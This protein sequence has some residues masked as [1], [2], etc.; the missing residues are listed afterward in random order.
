MKRILVGVAV[1]GALGV[2]I[3]YYINSTKKLP[4]VA[5]V[6]SEP[7][8]PRRGPVIAKPENAVPT[9]DGAKVAS[10]PAPAVSLDLPP[11]FKDGVRMYAN[12]HWEG[13]SRLQVQFLG[14]H[15]GV[16]PGKGYVKLMPL[17]VP[18]KARPFINTE[19]KWISTNPPVYELWHRTGARLPNDFRAVYVRGGTW[20][21][22]DLERS[23]ADGDQVVVTRPGEHGKPY[24][25]A[26]A[27]LPSKSKK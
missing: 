5:V 11:K 2:G 21:F 9:K 8:P 19:G 23:Y 24:V 6:P 18:D 27:D 10:V 13:D 17:V 7:Q 4:Q 26:A 20:W 14:P 12:V 1:L 16:V 15:L 25:K 22:V 3:G